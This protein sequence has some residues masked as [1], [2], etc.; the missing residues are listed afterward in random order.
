VIG[1][2]AVHEPDTSSGPSRT[3]WQTLAAAY[4]LFVGV[5]DSFIKRRLLIALSVVAGGALLAVLT[6]VALKLSVDSLTQYESAQWSVP[7]QLLPLGSVVLVMLYVVGQ[8]VTRLFSEL[9]QYTFGQAEQRL[10]RHVG[11]RLFDHL[12]RL[13]LRFHLDRKTGAIGEAS[14]QGIR[15]YQLILTHVTFTILPVVI[16]LLAVAVVLLHFGYGSYLLI[17]GAASIAYVVAFHRGALAIRD[18][19]GDTAN[20]HID[21]HAVLTDSLLNYETIKYFDAEPVVA[22]RYDK[23]L[24]KVESAWSAFYTRRM[25]NG[26]VVAT[27]FSLSLGVS[28]YFAARDVTRGAMTVGDFVL[29]NAYIIRLAQPLEL[30]GFA[31]RDVAQGVAFLGRLLDLLQ[32]S[33]ES[34]SSRTSLDVTTSQSQL[35]FDRVSFGYQDGRSVLR[36]VSFVVPAGATVALVG[37]SGSG[38]S[39]IIRLLF[40]LY[41]PDDGRILLDG[42]PISGLPLSLLRRSVAVVPQDTVLFHDTIASNIGFGRHGASESEIEEAARVANLHDLIVSLPKG[43]DTLVGERG[44]KLSGGERQRVAIARA[45]LKRPRIYVFDEATSSL[46]T[47]T[48]REILR[49]L[50][51]VSARCTTLVIAHRLSTVVHA[52]EILVLDQGSIIERGKHEE[53]LERNGAYATLWRAQHAN[54]T[55]DT[56]NQPG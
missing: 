46:D 28:L 25:E 33:R 35:A 18:S 41:E 4:L 42:I 51:A 30:L 34:D 53:L 14:E 5:A 44:L 29:V 39:S 20:S 19:A 52:D 23:A 32:Q 45:A 21:A 3:S 37:A 27:I 7:G 15:G 12:V 16:E 47:R 54:E 40:R 10:R 43:Y 26:A 49:N 48:E 2:E 55:L 22:S 31:V 8:Y 24:G 11:A 1:D 17:I 50:N 56:A 36:D 13:P 38:K 6:P 9:R